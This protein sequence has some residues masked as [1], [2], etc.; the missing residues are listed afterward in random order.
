MAEIT[1][2][3]LYSSKDLQWFPTIIKVSSLPRVSHVL[4]TTSQSNLIFN[5]SHRPQLIP[6]FILLPSLQSLVPP[7]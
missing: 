6:I 4:T 5:H 3:S 1:L 2:I 7:P